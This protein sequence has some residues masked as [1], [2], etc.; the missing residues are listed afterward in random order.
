MLD[1]GTT[2]L[3]YNYGYNPNKGEYKSMSSKDLVTINGKKYFQF[4]GGGINA[5]NYTDING[6][7]PIP[8]EIAQAYRYGISGLSLS[9][10]DYSQYSVIYQIFVNKF[11]WVKACSDG[12]DC[13]YRKDCP[14]SGIRVA[15][16][17]KSQKQ[18][19]LDSWNKDIGT[20]DVK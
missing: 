18:Y 7:N 12:E 11:G 8:R 6:N 5:I 14:M 17:P 10:K 19:V 13:M 15:L 9:L 16:V 4:G 1:V 3:L 2:G 20:Y